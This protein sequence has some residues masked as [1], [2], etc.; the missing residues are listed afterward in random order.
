MVNKPGENV[1]KETL[2]YSIVPVCLSEQ[3]LDWLNSGIS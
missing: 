3:A 1:C 2:D